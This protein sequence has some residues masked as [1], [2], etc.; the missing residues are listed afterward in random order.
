MSQGPYFYFRQSKNVHYFAS[1]DNGKMR[2]GEKE[3]HK[4]GYSNILRRHSVNQPCVISLASIFV[5]HLLGEEK[6]LHR[7]NCVLHKQLL[8]WLLQSSFKGM[9]T[10]ATWKLKGEGVTHSIR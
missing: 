6:H 2:Q 5:L 10:Q 4:I 1:Y 7:L 9:L 8:K 3:H